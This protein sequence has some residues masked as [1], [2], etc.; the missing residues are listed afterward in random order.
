MQNYKAWESYQSYVC[1]Y[2]DLQWELTVLDNEF[3]QTMLNF[4]FGT[5]G[6][7]PSVHLKKARSIYDNWFTNRMFRNYGT[8][9]YSSA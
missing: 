6:Y 2:E 4:I 8:S 1:T 3:N 5:K 7:R 9:E